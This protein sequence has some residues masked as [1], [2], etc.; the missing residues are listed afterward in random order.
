[1]IDQPGLPLSAK[2][3]WNGD[4]DARYVQ[5][6]PL[7]NYLVIVVHWF[8]GEVD[9]SGKLATIALWAASFICLQ[10]IWRELLSARQAVW[11]NL[12]F[13]IAPLSVFYGQAFMPEMLIQLLAFAFI[14]QV[15]SYD[16]QPSL[17]RWFLL[18]ATGLVGLLVKLPEISHLYLL[19]G[20]VIF[21]RER[22]KGLVR[23][24]YLIAGAL[25]LLTLFA[26]S[27]YTAAVNSA[28]LPEWS[29]RETLRLFIGSWHDRLLIRRWT[30]TV[31]YLGAFILT[32]PAI[33]A[34][35]GGLWLS[36]REK[37]N[38]LLK[39]WLLSLGVF[40]LLWFGNGPG[41]QSY[42][43]LPALAPLCALFGIGMSKMFEQQN[44]ARWPRAVGALAVLLVVL[45]ALAVSLY[46]FQQDRSIFS[47][48]QWLREHTQS[49]EVV[50]FC[51]NHHWAS[52]DYPY[53]AALAHYSQRPTFVWTKNTPAFF[54]E[55]ALKRAK[56]AVITKPQPPSSALL[57]KL[58]RFRKAQLLPASTEWLAEEGFLPLAGQETFDVYR[59]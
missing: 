45:P 26:W 21:R 8:A 46:L 38:S 52:V 25:T 33:L 35:G 32:G 5:E 36:L 55:E 59:R 11:A 10:V 28:A 50:L 13:V 58:N 43:N 12:L 17:A 54:R 16:R 20:V 14:L 57:E 48:A 22:W 41:N 56:Y 9:L 47:A 24:A 27:Q 37:E 34:A 39:W 4:L 23:P 1:M 53:N 19:L 42:Y 30:V 7:Y 44:I 2:I 51:P 3:P 6:L 15:F 40:Y 31:L 49:H 18:A 29:S